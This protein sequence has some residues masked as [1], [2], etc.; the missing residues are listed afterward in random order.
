MLCLTGIMGCFGAVVVLGLVD[1]QDR[2]VSSS[3]TETMVMAWFYH[4]IMMVFGSALKVS[5][6][7]L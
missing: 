2:T 1:V 6:P 5:P 7:E 3:T 4:R